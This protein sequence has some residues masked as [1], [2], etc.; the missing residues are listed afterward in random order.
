MLGG[1]AIRICVLNVTSEDT[2]ECNFEGRSL[3]GVY[4]NNTEILCVS[5]R[6]SQS[7]PV[8]LQFTITRDGESV[9]NG[10]ATFHVCKLYKNAYT[11]QACSRSKRTLHLSQV[12][13]TE[14]I[15]ERL[16][17]QQDTL[18]FSTAV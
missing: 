7:G 6:F 13:Y 18:S 4:L 5:P 9:F 11:V 8:A 3:P 17:I 14:P 12:L 2:I 16:T 1:T 10:E 15:P